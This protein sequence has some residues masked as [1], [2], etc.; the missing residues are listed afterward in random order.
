M[1]GHTAPFSYSPRG[2][3]QEDFPQQRWTFLQEDL[4]ESPLQR[5]MLRPSG[6]SIYMQRKEYVDGL[7]KNSDNLHVRVEHLFTCELDGKE[8][9]T[10]DDCVAKLKRLDAKGRLW[11]QEM[12]VE[13]QGGY[14]ILNDIETKAELEALPLS[15][16]RQTRAVLD[17]CAY[18]SLLTVTLEERR[19]RLPQVYM[20]QCEE[21]GAEV[22][23]GDLDKAVQLAG[24]EVDARRDRS[25]IRV[26]L[27]NVAGHH[28]LGTFRQPEP[29]RPVQREWTPP[30]PVYPPPQW[31]M[32][33][34]ETRPLPRV[35]APQK[36]M[37]PGPDIV[38]EQEFQS[39][40][41]IPL[42]VEE[43]DAERSTEIFNHVLNDLEIF[44]TKVSAVVNAQS[45]QE[46][47]SKKKMKIKTKK[48]AA[49]LP[50]PE[51]YISCLQKMKYGFNLLGQ[52]DGSLNT[53][54]APD[55]VHIFFGSLATIVPLYPADVPPSVLAPLLTVK[56][57]RLISQATEPEEDQLWKSL[58]DTWN[59]PRSRW[60][61]DVPPYLP[62]FYDGW[63]LPAPKHMPSPPQ[64]QNGPASRRN[65]LR[66]PP[67]QP[68]PEPVTNAPWSTRPPVH[69][70]EQPVYVKVVYDFMARNN[71]ELSIFKGEV[72]QVIQK[73][74]QWWLVRNGRGEEGNVPQ[75]VLEPERGPRPAEDLLRDTRGPVTLD[76][77]SASAEV[78]AWLE[79]KGFSRITVSTLG[80]LTGKLLLG[81]SKHEIQTACPEEGGKVFFQLQA[82]KSAIALASE[83]SG[84]Y[85][86]RY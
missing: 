33:E 20:F 39:I 43:H 80:V 53:P 10:L 68:R 12:I 72:V 52:L 4:K 56:A 6:K 65:S 41:G 58:G 28:A 29:P 47:K 54:T 16:V 3:P 30:P 86:G 60:P 77:N 40:P 11:P 85:G 48:N 83:P 71:Q 31:N 34:P 38:P 49:R 57:L 76:M 17:S 19:K 42:S 25:D 75:N 27:G 21:T 37:M 36:E 64:Y 9:R 67:D 2:F 82:F 15:H 14:L 32:R 50:P 1:Y 51:E 78:K 8:L 46:K 62:Q 45:R 23:K 84:R 59:V 18:N 7:N 55:F 73:T 79:Y 26:H 35:H 74:R 13:A 69:P 5:N 61:N 63:Q 24:G 22:I 70:S 81:M 66:I 44:M